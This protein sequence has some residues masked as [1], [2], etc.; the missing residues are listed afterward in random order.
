[1]PQIYSVYV[2]ITFKKTSN[3]KWGFLTS[4][5]KLP[6]SRTFN[7][8]RLALSRPNSFH[9]LTGGSTALQPSDGEVVRWRAANQPVVRGASLD[10]KKLR[11][12]CKKYADSDE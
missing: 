3:S 2:N 6:P 8:S 7:I 5:I 4:A 10:E 9:P 1:M 11:W 12:S